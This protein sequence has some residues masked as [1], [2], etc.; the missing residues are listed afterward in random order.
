MNEAPFEYSFLDQDW[1]RQYQQEQRLGGL[2]SVFAGLSLL[3]AMIGL[4]G[5][6]TYSA[7]QRKKEIGVRKV[8]GAS[9]NQVV[10]LIE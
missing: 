3:I 2:F 4:V 7:E 6:V 10:F 9:V 1:A 5:L 8:L